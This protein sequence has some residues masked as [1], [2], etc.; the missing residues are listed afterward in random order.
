MMYFIPAGFKHHRFPD[1]FGVIVSPTNHDSG[2]AIVRI[3]QGWPWICDNG[4][5]TQKFE[6]ERFYRFL[7][8][9]QPYQHQCRF[10]VAPDVVSD[11]R[12]T[13]D[14]FP[15][16]APRIRSLGYRVAYAA[17]DGQEQLPFPDAFD[18]LFVGGST[19]WKLG[20]EADACIGQAQRLG[21]WVHVG[22]VNTLKR[23]R[24]FSLVNVDSVDGTH[25][26]FRPDEY[27][28]R[29]IRWT[30][31]RPLFVLPAEQLPLDGCDILEMDATRS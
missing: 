18:A 17:Q 23:L 13:L 16:F 31:I 12:A 10:V 24:H 6:P 3:K 4:A 2:S 8:K 22:R 5:F 14:H 9:M 1:W 11:A 21:K 25:V 29:L 28:P 20:P 7:E 15:E 19:A 30:S 26:V 27:V